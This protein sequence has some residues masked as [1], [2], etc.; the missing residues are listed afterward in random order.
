MREQSPMASTSRAPITLQAAGPAGDKRGQLGG[1][2]VGPHKAWSVT[3]T[4]T[5]NAHSVAQQAPAAQQ[6]Q[7]QQAHRRK[8]STASL[9]GRS[10]GWYSACNRNEGGRSKQFSQTVCSLSQQCLSLI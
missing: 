5:L 2:F 9:E 4:V 6:Q 3:Q 7:A 1:Q 10:P 8:G